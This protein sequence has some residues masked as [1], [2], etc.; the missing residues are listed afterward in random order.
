VSASSMTA[1]ERLSDA[2][3][4][5]RATARASPTAAVT[6]TASS[7]H[8]ALK[9]RLSLGCPTKR[10]ADDQPGAPHL[11]AREAVQG[12]RNAVLQRL[13]GV[14][15]MTMCESPPLLLGNTGSA[16]RGSADLKS[17]STSTATS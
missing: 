14:S 11:A 17:P 1:I 5:G 13:G 12:R 16:I 10:G 8:N 2:K 7:R 6:S 3:T 15:A 4:S 9:G